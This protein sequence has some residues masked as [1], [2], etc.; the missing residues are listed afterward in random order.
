MHL[1]SLSGTW[2]TPVEAVKGIQTT[3]DYNGNKKKAMKVG[4]YKELDVALYIWFR[5]QQEKMCQ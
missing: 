2:T 1:E 4:D 5:Q 3:D